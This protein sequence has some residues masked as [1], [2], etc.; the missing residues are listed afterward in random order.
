VQRWIADPPREYLHDWL[1]AVRAT[2][3]HPIMNNATPHP[4]T[5][6]PPADWHQRHNR[7][8]L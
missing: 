3:D 6:H 7:V 4:E 1:S 8:H 5:N 2:L